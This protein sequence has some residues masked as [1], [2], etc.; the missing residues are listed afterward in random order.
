MACLVPPQ[1]ACG[2]QGAAWGDEGRT[3][4][5]AATYMACTKAACAE[6]LPR[7]TALT[8]A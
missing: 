8:A 4:R 1:R 5:E 7:H 3:L 6:S 2:V